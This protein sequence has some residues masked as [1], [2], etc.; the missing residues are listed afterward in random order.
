[1]I[2]LL[3]KT[4]LAGFGAVSM[5]QKKAEELLQ[6]LKQRLNV[7]EEEGRALLEKLQ[8]TA[9]ENQQRMEDLARQEVRL[10]CERMGVITADE[11]AEL[12]KKVAE[13][14]E[15]VKSLSQA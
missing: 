15:Q 8:E 5:S 14:E 10:A 13:L 7:S 6:E 4:V 2:E 3:E 12:Q 1:M 9:R 11:F